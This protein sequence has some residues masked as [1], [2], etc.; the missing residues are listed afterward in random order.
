MLPAASINNDRQLKAQAVVK[1]TCGLFEDT[2]LLQLELAPAIPT[3]AT[4]SHGLGKMRMHCA[5]PAFVTL[6]ALVAAADARDLLADAAAPAPAMMAASAPAP[7]MA[8]ASSAAPAPAPAADAAAAAPAVPP[9]PA[10]TPAPAGCALS[11]IQN[12]GS[13]SRFAQILYATPSSANLSAILSDQIAGITLFAPPNDAINATLEKFGLDFEGL[14]KNTHLCTQIMQYHILPSPIEYSAF[15]EGYS[16]NT[17]EEGGNDIR[18]SLRIRRNG[19]NIRIV[20]GKT[21]ATVGTN[22][23]KVCMDSI[24]PISMLLLPRDSIQTSTPSS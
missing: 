6:L 11:F 2:S 13:Y 24:F 19:D 21:T 16:F 5:L 22:G 1:H 3:A 20:S 15:K 9:T 17:L 10:A 18:D 14:L 12:N 8:P 23:A 7:M 4:Q